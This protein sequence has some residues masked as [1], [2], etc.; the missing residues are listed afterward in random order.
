MKTSYFT[1][2]LL[3][4]DITLYCGYTDDVTKRLATHNAGKG[5]KYTKSRLPVTLLTA[6]A[7]EDKKTAMKCEWWFKNKLNRRQ[8]LEMIEAKSIK[9]H[10]EK[11]MAARV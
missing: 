9:A 4:A 11:Y 1:Y 5:A 6:I 8:K 7:F 2:V 10:F 3:C